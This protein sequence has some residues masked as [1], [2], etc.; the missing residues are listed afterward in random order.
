MA[1]KLLSITIT[2]RIPMPE[3]AFEQIDVVQSVRG[4]VDEIVTNATSRLGY[5]FIAASELRGVRE[6]SSGSNLDRLRNVG[7][8]YKL[9]I[10]G[11][12]GLRLTTARTLDGYIDQM[13]ALIA[14]SSNLETLDAI[15]KHNGGALLRL[16]DPV[17]EKVAQAEKA[18]RALLEDQRAA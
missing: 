4:V 12:D 9:K 17:Q 8:G 14:R 15:M 6:Q 2:A 13:L 7:A 16:P 11:I 10:Y 5:Q 1:R 3:D 18:I